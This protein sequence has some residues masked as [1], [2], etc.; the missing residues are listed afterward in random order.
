MPRRVALPVPHTRVEYLI[1]A[2]RVEAFNG[3]LY[4]MGGGWDRITV[5]NLELPV[6]L[7]I[8]CGLLVPYNETD[9]DHRLTLA[10]R[11]VDGEPIAPPL[12]VGFRTGRAPTL[13]RGADTHIP[14]AIGAEFVFPD[15]GEF[16]VV[17]SIDD[18]LEDARRL[19]FFVAAAAAQVGGGPVG[20]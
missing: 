19:A 1:L 8:A 13:M 5:Q 9:D 17:A 15:A 11:T 7:S 16:S 20:R 10:I 3:K 6:Q 4:M 18:R 2:D 14:F 12:E